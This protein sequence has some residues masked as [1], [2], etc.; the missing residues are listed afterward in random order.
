MGVNVDED[1]EGDVETRAVV[2]VELDVIKEGVVDEMDGKEVETW[3]GLDGAIKGG[4]STSKGIEEE[5]LP[6][7]ASGIVS[8]VE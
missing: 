5:V 8:S 2:D 7:L 6:D 1:E 3:V 4:S